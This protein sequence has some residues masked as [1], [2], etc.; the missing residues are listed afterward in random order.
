MP[1]RQRLGVTGLSQFRSSLRRMDREAAKGL[2][3]ALND[4]AQLLVDEA[5][6]LIPTRTGAARASLK[7]RSTQGAVRVAYG[8]RKAPYMPWLDFG[9]RTG[10]AR[11]VVRPFLSEG[12][13]LYPTLRRNRSEFEDLL[14]DRIA[15]VARAAGVEVS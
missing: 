4:A 14:L 9:G 3:V 12:R 8:G 7:A 6:P 1:G 10:P 5:R 15:G 2:R 13:Y 11:S